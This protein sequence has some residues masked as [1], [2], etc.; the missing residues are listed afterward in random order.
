M[1]GGPEGGRY[2]GWRRRHAPLNRFHLSERA[3]FVVLALNHQRGAGN[4]FQ[5]FFDVPL[6]EL[7]IEPDVVPSAKG[8]IDVIVIGR[9]SFRKVGG[10]VEF[11]NRG[12]ASDAQILHKNVRRLKSKS[13]HALGPSA[14][15]NQSDGGAVAVSKKNGPLNL[16][17][18]E[19]FRKNYFG[20]VM[21]EV[22]R[23]L[24]REAFRFSMAVARI[25]QNAAA[26][27]LRHSLRE[28]FPH[29]DG[30]EAFVEH[31]DSGIRARSWVQQRFQ[32]LSVHGRELEFLGRRGQTVPPQK[33]LENRFSKTQ[34]WSMLIG[35]SPRDPTLW[36]REVEAVRKKSIRTG[37]L[38]SVVTYG[39]CWQRAPWFRFFHRPWRRF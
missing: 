19:Q 26:G 34:I 37:E 28:I 3:V 30:P 25:H 13:A 16:K 24:L 11:A 2:Q 39:K 12:D 10:L 1:R 33:H 7:R 14:C 35:I 38:C 32:A 9:Q 23:A 4:C 21:H 18:A 36:V 22:S 20:F 8:A 15:V 27:G 17:R 6:A 31:D 29:G 5:I